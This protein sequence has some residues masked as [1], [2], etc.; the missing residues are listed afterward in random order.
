MENIFTLLKDEK[1]LHEQFVLLN[2]CELFDPAKNLISQIASEMSDE[3]G[4]FVEQF[5]TQG[6]EA[7]LWELFLNNFFLEND[8]EV[9]P[10][11]RPDFKIK[12]N[13]IE[14]FVEASTSNPTDGDK[15]SKEFIQ[16]SIDKKD[17]DMQNELVDYYV[18]KLGSVLYSKVNKKYWEIE[19][20]K[21]KPLILAITP[22]HNYLS[23]FLPDSKIIEYLYGIRW[24]V[25]KNEDGSASI[26]SEKI[27]THTHEV[28]GKVKEIPSCFFEQENVENISAVLFSNN[29][30]LHKFNRMGFEAGLSEKELIMVRS[31]LCFD[32]TPEILEPKKFTYNIEKG[33]NKENWKEGVSIM[34]NPNAKV[35]LDTNLFTDMRQIWINEKGGLEQIMPEFYPYNSL[36]IS[37]QMVENT[38]KTQ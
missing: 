24:V 16:E 34:H 27:D 6:F 35:K 7:R 11:E 17:I 22:C 3:D 4:N 19:D 28:D 14:I 12:K 18:I 38:E 10:M 21:D 30:D 25:A 8:F 29:C 26:S 1:E 5:Q 36:T 13:D 37:G 23:K 2:N 31:G 33:Q 20:V 9:V 32:E 15:Y